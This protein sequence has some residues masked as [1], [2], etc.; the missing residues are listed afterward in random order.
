M[1]QIT[2]DIWI[3]A[4]Q[5]NILLEKITLLQTTYHEW[6]LNDSVFVAICKT[7]FQPD[8]DLFATRI[9]T[10]LERFV[11]WFLDPEA[12]ASDAFSIGWNKFLAYIFPLFS[13]IQRVLQKIEEEKVSIALL[14]IPMWITQ[15]WYPRL[16]NCLVDMLRKLLFRKHL[17]MLIHNNQ[18]HPMNK[19]KLFL[20]ACTV[21]GDLLKIEEFQNSL[22]KLFFNHE[23]PPLQ[24]SITING[25]NCHF[26]VI[27]GKLIPLLPLT[28]N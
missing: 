7:F 18:A 13:I 2:K 21:P 14:I 9:N 19:R 4:A 15:P 6:K 8:I 26:G 1:L 16:L 3:W 22:K 20:I 24:K 23:E 25:E 17:L 10:Q 11:S 12:V 28:F 5:R 27:N